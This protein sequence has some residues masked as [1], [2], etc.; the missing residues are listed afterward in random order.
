MFGPSVRLAGLNGGGCCPPGPPGPGAPVGG[1]PGWPPGGGAPPPGWPPG[2][3][4]AK[5]P[6]GGRFPG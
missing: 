3:G 5:L 4:A 6:P 1:P 2:G